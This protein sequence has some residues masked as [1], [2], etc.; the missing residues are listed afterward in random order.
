MTDQ[1]KSLTL[2]ELAKML[3]SNSANPSVLAALNNE[4]KRRCE[5]AGLFVDEAGFARG[6]LM[7]IDPTN[8]SL[9][10]VDFRKM[11]FRDAQ[12]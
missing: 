8:V 11:S 6:V 4:I 12:S 10:N 5:E 1:L 7:G 2:D 9:P 3:F